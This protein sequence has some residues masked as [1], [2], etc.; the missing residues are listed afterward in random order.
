MH[1]F[2][3]L[4]L[5]MM[6]LVTYIYVEPFKL[7]I[8]SSQ[9]RLSPDRKQ[10]CYCIWLKYWDIKWKILNKF[11]LFLILWGWTCKWLAYC[12]QDCEISWPNSR[13]QDFVWIVNKFN[14]GNSK[15]TIY[16]QCPDYSLHQSLFL[17]NHRLTLCAY[18]FPPKLTL[19]LSLS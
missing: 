6:S 2:P 11:W 1:V 18:F 7:S 17:K 15:F 12:F 10:K 9:Q 5:V 14:M 19:C 13:S 3:I 8:K 16:V 4:N